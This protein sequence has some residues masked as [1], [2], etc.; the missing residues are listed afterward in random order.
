MGSSLNSHF[1]MLLEL[2]LWL[3]ELKNVS[4]FINSESGPVAF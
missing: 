3:T 4:L 2:Y 1:K